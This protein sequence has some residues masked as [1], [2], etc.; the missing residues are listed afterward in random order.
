MRIALGIEYDGSDFSG[1]QAQVGCKTVQG[2]LEAALSKVAA[3][4]IAVFCAGRT[5]A[6]V[7]AS[8]QVVH[9]DTQA[10]RVLKAWVFGT[11]TLL[12]PSISVRWAVVVDDA[13]H[14]RFSA[15]ARR[16]RYVIYNQPVRSALLVRRASLHFQPLDVTRMQNAAN[17]LLGEHDFSSL[18][19]SRCESKTPMRTV[20]EITVLRQGDLVSFE[21][22]AN[23]FLHHMVRNIAGLLMRV[24]AGF[25]E[26]EWI[27]EVIA[28]KDRRA[29]AETATPN[30]LYLMQVRYKAPYEFPPVLSMSALIG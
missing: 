21:I 14:A 25:A 20:H 13:F 5:D 15:V 3:E 12:P 6:G 7:H 10:A 29:A 18:R 22:E 19:S 16:Y 24:G 30:G 27:G 8:G 11:N 26:P 23:A 9:F 17:Y 4:P 2:L 1:W 28:A